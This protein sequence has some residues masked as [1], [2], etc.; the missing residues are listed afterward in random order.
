[1]ANW[2]YLLLGLGIGLF[3]ALVVWIVMAFKKRSI[4]KSSES[5]LAKYKEM[6]TQR[7]E[8]ESEGMNKLKKENES[9]KSANEN[10]RVSLQTMSQKPGKR[11]VARLQV[12]QTAVDRLTIN[13]PG[14]GPAWQAALKESE[15]EF[16]K[17]LSGTIP[18]LRKYVPNKTDAQLIEED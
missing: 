16:S 6:L 8:L 17:T 9:L 13:S 11:E 1:M 2:Q 7:M 5:E 10:L 3:I 12:Y 4:K 14:F 15:E 18:F